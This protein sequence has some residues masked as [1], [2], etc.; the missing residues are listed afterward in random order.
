MTTL[1]ARHAPGLALDQET[2]NGLTFYTIRH[3]DATKPFEATYTFT[4]GYMI[5]GPSKALVMNAISHSPKRKLAGTFH[6]FQ[7][8]ASSG[9]TA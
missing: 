7:S 3:L 1:K 6:G 5:L 2:A 9:R 8:V 4:D